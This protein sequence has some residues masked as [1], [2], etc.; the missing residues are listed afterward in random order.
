MKK[1]RQKVDNTTCCTLARDKHCKEFKN[2][3]DFKV[4]LENVFKFVTIGYV[5]LLEH[6]MFSIY[7]LPV[8]MFF[9]Y[10]WLPSLKWAGF[11]WKEWPNLSKLLEAS[12]LLEDLLFRTYCLDQKENPWGGDYHLQWSTLYILACGK[13]RQNITRRLRTKLLNVFP[14]KTLYEL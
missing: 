2:I 10:T 3:W 1:N 14:T 5:S 6:C 4:S 12:I 7:M 11:L 13:E 9:H 8:S